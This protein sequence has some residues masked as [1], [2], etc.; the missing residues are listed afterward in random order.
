ME[1]IAFELGE[2]TNLNLEFDR[3]VQGKEKEFPELNLTLKY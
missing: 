2:Q 1:N 3:K